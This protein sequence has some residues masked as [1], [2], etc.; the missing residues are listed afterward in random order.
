VWTFLTG[1]IS[2]RVLNKKKFYCSVLKSSQ[3][4]QEY[5]KEYVKN[6]G[7]HFNQSIV[8]R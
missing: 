6:K 8:N 1:L 5:A 4:Q 3:D 7:F 2:Q